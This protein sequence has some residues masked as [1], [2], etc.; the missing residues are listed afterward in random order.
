MNIRC[1]RCKPEEGVLA[2]TLVRMFNS[3]TKELIRSWYL[4][5]LHVE[6]DF[7]PWLKKRK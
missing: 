2:E 7:G 4:C 3:D 1:Q 6:V 5:S